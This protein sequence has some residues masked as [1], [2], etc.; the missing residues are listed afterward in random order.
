MKNYIHLNSS[1]KKFNIDGIDMIGNMHNGA[2]IGLNRNGLRFIEDRN[3][4]IYLHSDILKSN[5]VEDSELFEALR[6]NMFF[7]N[8]M[9][10]QLNSAYVHVTHNCNLHCVG[11]YSFV[12][13]RNSKNNLSFDEI[14][15]IFYILKQAGVNKIVISGGEPFLRNDF[16]D[17]CKYAKEN[18]QLEDLCVITNG[19]MP[20]E[21]YKKA[22][23]YID[24]L[25]ISVDGYSEITGFIRDKGIMPKVI[26]TIN[27][28]KSDVKINLISTLHKKNKNLMKNYVDFSNKLG[29]TLS[30]SIFTVDNSTNQFDDYILNSQDLIDVA[31]NLTDIDQSIEIMDFP[32][33]DICLSCK[34]RC[35]AGRSLISIDANGDIYPC[36]MLHEEKLKL[37]N[38]LRDNVLEI[39]NSNL[40]PFKELCV[41]NFEECSGCN[42]KYICGGG[43]RGRSYFYHNKITSSDSYCQF[44]KKYYKS[45]I[46]S[47]KDLVCIE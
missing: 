20:L 44:M 27:E 10:N 13:K 41:D 9:C 31:N 32:S 8:N 47:I 11:C 28:L 2:I 46:K 23:P 1:V 30:F 29:V 19:T 7:E 45:A 35:E 39:L 38:I 40:N 12:E 33:K 37:G 16:T 36:H 26:D 21:L 14:C 34:E 43:C 4:G 42:Y 6:N 25:C 5:N 17:I 15:K 24:E 18:I 22:I 3:D